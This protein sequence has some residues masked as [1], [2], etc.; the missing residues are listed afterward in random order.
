LTAPGFDEDDLDREGNFPAQESLA[1]F[2]G[3]LRSAY[4]PYVRHERISADKS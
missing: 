1:G 3:E 4:A 2:E